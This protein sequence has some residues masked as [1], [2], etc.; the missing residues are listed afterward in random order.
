MRG[1]QVGELKLLEAKVHEHQ[2]HGERVGQA[3]ALRS[4]LTAHQLHGAAP[5]DVDGG[6]EP[7]ARLASLAAVSGAPAAST[8]SSSWRK[9]SSISHGPTETRRAGPMR[10]RPGKTRTATPRS[11]RAAPSSAAA[12]GGLLAPGDSGTSTKLAAEGMTCRPLPRNSSV[13]RLRLAMVRSTTDASHLGSPRSTANAAAS[14]EAVTLYGPRDFST[15]RT[16]SAGPTA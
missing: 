16:R 13:R 1:M 8:A 7:H 15:S 6:E 11:R 5:A 3:H 2:R 4:R 12:S 14:A 9:R 10:V